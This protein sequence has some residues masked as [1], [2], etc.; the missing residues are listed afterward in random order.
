MFGFPESITPPWQT[1]PNVQLRQQND[2]EVGPATGQWEPPQRGADDQVTISEESRFETGEEDRNRES[3]GETETDLS[4]DK[5]LSEEER[6]QVEKLK[7]RDAEVKAHERS[8]MAAGGDVVQGAASYEYVTGPDGRQYAVS[9]EVKIDASPEGDPEKTIEKMHRVKQ[10]AMAPADP[11]GQDRS[12]AAQASMAESRARAVLNQ[13]ER[14]IH[15]AASEGD[16]EMMTDNLKALDGY[17]EQ[18]NRLSEGIARLPQDDTVSMAK[19]AVDMITIKNGFSANVK[20]ID[21]QL[22]LEKNLVDIF[23]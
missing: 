23:A 15:E 3:K 7:K 10:A 6:Q 12:A 17:M 18:M 8:H 9:G 22:D 13:Q 5:S 2:E 21:A 19:S 16:R 4:T 14:E 11:S 20:A 1:D